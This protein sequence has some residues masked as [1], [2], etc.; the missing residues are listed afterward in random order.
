MNPK[1][2]VTYN[3]TTSIILALIITAES[4]LHMLKHRLNPN[5]AYT[6][7]DS[8]ITTG[9]FPAEE[10]N[11]KELGKYKLE[12]NITSAYFLKK[13]NLCNQNP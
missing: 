3:K 9:D 8:I 12:H 7:T 2:Q 10:I 4:R 6:D 13:K 5:T 11:N 1:K